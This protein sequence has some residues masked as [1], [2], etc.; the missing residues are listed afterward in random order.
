MTCHAIYW[1]KAIT[2]SKDIDG[3]D[4]LTGGYVRQRVK[5]HVSLETISPVQVR[6]VE[7]PED[8]SKNIHARNFEHY[9]SSLSRVG[10]KISRLEFPPYTVEKISF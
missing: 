3:S 1:Q 5:R 9:P 6:F 10:K 8:N 4:R 7:I 2:K